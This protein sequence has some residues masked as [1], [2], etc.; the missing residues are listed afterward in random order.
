VVKARFSFSMLGLLAAGLLT[1]CALCVLAAG[2]RAESA[3]E[4]LLP[5]CAPTTS[6]DPAWNV[7]ESDWE[8]HVEENTSV[9]ITNQYVGMGLAQDCAYQSYYDSEL[10]CDGE[11]NC[12][13][14]DISVYHPFV[15]GYAFPDTFDAADGDHQ[16]VT[17][18]LPGTTPNPGASIP[19]VAWGACFPG[20]KWHEPLV[21][22]GCD[23]NAWQYNSGENTSLPTSTDSFPAQGGAMIY[24]P[25]SA[26]GIFTGPWTA[27]FGDASPGFHL[28]HVGASP[29]VSADTSCEYEL[30]FTR[31]PTG[32][33]QV[34]QDMQ[35]VLELPAE[36]SGAE[37]PYGATV[38]VPMLVIQTGGSGSPGTGSGIGGG[39]GSGGSGSGS[40]SGGGSGGGGGG[41]GLVPRVTAAS[42]TV[43]KV[44]KLTL[45]RAK[46][47]LA[48][49][50]CKAG[51]TH[52]A[53]SPS[54]KKG[55]VIAAT[56]PT[57][58][59]P[60]TTKPVDL[61]VSRGKKPKRSAAD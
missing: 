53:Y 16:R 6:A 35:V 59:K 61:K 36:K 52:R 25:R 41:A 60:A 43:P 42:C 50:H 44:A 55:L 15:P 31:D 28:Q 33:L 10:I 38:A 11:G 49:A 24:R 57:G 26:G 34:T 21:M 45:A 1:C 48:A 19:G 12:H 14:S 17:I 27:S 5:I 47:A 3:E 7:N 32:Q 13:P 56:P 58:A 22:T 18:T 51:A 2:A 29:C 8:S 23:P 4:G 37:G 46:A 39:S 20:F 9:G 54:V 40:G 30:D